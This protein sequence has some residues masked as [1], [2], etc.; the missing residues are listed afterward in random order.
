MHVGNFFF[1]VSYSNPK[2]L[3]P[4]SILW[5]IIFIVSIIFSQ[6]FS[7]SCIPGRI[8]D[9]SGGGEVKTLYGKKLYAHNSLHSLNPLTA[10]FTPNFISPSPLVRI[11]CLMWCETVSNQWFGVSCIFYN[12][13]K[14]RKACL[15]VGVS[16][17]YPWCGFCTIY[18]TRPN[19][20]LVSRLKSNL[21][22]K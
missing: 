20:W 22:T 5:N 13:S 2:W 3:L 6:F 16:R 14:Y 15:S 4:C 18:Q 21:K 8:Q 10:T 19:N 17:Q 12:Y 11:S 9:F 7:I 1:F